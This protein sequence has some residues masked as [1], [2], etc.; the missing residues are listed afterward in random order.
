MTHII[1]L[2]SPYISTF[3][4]FVVLCV[5][6]SLVNNYAGLLVLRFLLG[7]FGSPALATGG[8]SYGDFYEDH[9][10]PYAIA[11]WGGGATLG[12][13]SVPTQDGVD[14]LLLTSTA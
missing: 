4:V 12:P 1:G 2:D 6:T 13:V 3:F 5:P 8:A 9:Q 10:M 14:L 7:F 11:L